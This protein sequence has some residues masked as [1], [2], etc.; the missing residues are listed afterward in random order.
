MFGCGRIFYTHHRC[1]EKD[2]ISKK[3]WSGHNRF[4]HF[5]KK[6]FVT[7]RRVGVVGVS[8]K[9]LRSLPS[10]SVDDILIFA[11]GKIF[12]ADAI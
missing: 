11:N 2:K 8:I 7:R 9:R 5:Q 3:P 6:I 4:L 12:T 10:S 1:P